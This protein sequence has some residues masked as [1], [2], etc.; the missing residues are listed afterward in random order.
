MAIDRASAVGAEL[1]G[2]DVSWD[3]TD[4]LLYHLALGAGAD[5]LSW[6]YEGALRGV[7]P[8]FA[9][10]VTTLGDTEPPQVRMPGISVDLARTVHGEQ[11]IVLRQP[12][13]T[14]GRT[15]A[16]ARIVDVYD[17]GASAVIVTET[18]TEFFTSRV[19][20][21][22]RGEGGFGGSRGPS[23]RVQP[24]QRAPDVQLLAPTETRQA[25]L[26][27]LLGDR[28]PLHADPQFAALAGFSRPILH[29][30]CTYGI[31]CKAAVDA[32]LDGDPDR[33]GAYRA[34]F[35]GVV[36]PGETLRIS[37]WREDARLVLTAT[38]VDRDDAPALSDAV[39]TVRQP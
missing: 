22:A 2:R 13:P 21:F 11:E 27:R 32:M 29:G 10:V 12:I 34:R 18:S 6:V 17:K 4:V 19:S 9:T 25:L 15:R 38:V 30:L 8:T 24:P 26:Y 1:P 5:E 14:T 36:F 39:L 37:I 23:T 33:V 28:N 35:S 3:S 16:T 31:V 7:L 20:I